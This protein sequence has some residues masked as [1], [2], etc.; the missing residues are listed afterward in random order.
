MASVNG[1]VSPAPSGAARLWTRWREPLTPWLWT[2]LALFF[3][4]VFLLWPVVNTI[5]LSLLSFDSSSFVG[6]KNYIQIFT[7]QNLLLVLRNNVLWLIVATAGTVLFGLIIAVL[8]DRVR[9][10]S[11]V[12]AA[13]FIPMAISFVGAGVIWLLVYD[14]NPQVGLLNAVI[15]RLGFPAQAWTINESINNFA[16]MAVYIWIWTGFCMV[17]LSAALKGVPADVLEAARVDG[18]NEIQIFFRVIVPIISPTIAVV[19]TT[20][21]INVLKIFDVVY[22]MTGGNYNTSVVAMQYY[23]EEF[24]FNDFGIASALAVV[25]LIAVIPIMYVN[26]RRFRAQEAGR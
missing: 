4:V 16:I 24:N 3:V 9:I 2:G 21:L 20:M 19:A 5:W 1:T 26:L 10:E 13:I 23:K 11:T 17:I 7:S 12:K 14:L 15:T 8:V 25:L 18:A 6:L 22:V